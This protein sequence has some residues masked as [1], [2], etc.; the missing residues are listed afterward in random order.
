MRIEDSSHPLEYRPERKRLRAGIEEGNRP[1][2][3]GNRREVPTGVGERGPADLAADPLVVV[4]VTD[5]VELLALGEFVDRLEVFAVDQSDAKAV[6]LEV[7]DPAV[8]FAGAAEGLEAGL[9]S[10]DLA[11]VVL[12]G[13]DIYW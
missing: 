5:V 10:G 11:V 8:E 13:A 7:G 1:V 2:V 12:K 9:E 4:A 3:V 6:E